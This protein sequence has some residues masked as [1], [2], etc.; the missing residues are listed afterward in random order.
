MARKRV[1]LKLHGAT[2]MYADSVQSPFAGII[3]MLLVLQYK[4]NI[5]WLILLI[6]YIH[7]LLARTFDLS[8]II[9]EC[10]PFSFLEKRKENKY[11]CKIIFDNRGCINY[12]NETVN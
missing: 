1:F 8:Y 9:H 3:Q 11:C 10:T 6:L 12:E 5:C 2:F 4:S 7:V